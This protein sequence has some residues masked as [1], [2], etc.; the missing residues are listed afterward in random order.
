MIKNIILYADEKFDDLAIS[1]IKSFNRFQDSYNF[2]YYNIGFDSKIKKD[3]VFKIYVE[4][5][6]NI[7]QT[8]FYKSYICNKASKILDHYLYIDCDVIP[9][10][11]FNYKNM[12]I[13]L[14][15]YPKAVKTRQWQTPYLFWQD[16]KG[17]RHSRGP[18]ILCKKLNVANQTQNWAS[19]CI[20]AV[21]NTCKDFLQEWENVCFD[22]NL[23]CIGEKPTFQ[24]QNTIYYAWCLY[25]PLGDETA[26]NA[27]FW[28]YKLNNYFYE[29][30]YIETQNILSILKIENENIFNEF[31]EPD[32]PVSYVN[33]SKNIYFYHQIK[34]ELLRKSIFKSLNINE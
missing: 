1:T 33:N 26:L 8:T 20:L 29:N 30:I 22:K 15:T 24:F 17:I 9:S 3:N 23:W 7:P 4:P 5:I 6:S 14:D 11:H 27:L 34:N 2:Y 13:G 18:D 12:F 10:A 32:N 21:N 16:E 25:F 19:G 31:L 28:K